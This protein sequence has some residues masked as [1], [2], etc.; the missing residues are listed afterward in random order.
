MQIVPRH[1]FWYSSKVL[2]IFVLCNINSWIIFL[3][4]FFDDERYASQNEYNDEWLFDLKETG[5]TS[6][7]RA[8]SRGFVVLS[9]DSRVD[10]S[11]TGK[12]PGD[13]PFFPEDL[14]VRLNFHG[15]NGFFC[16]RSA[17]SA[18]KGSRQ[19][20]TCIDIIILRHVLDGSLKMFFIHSLHD[21]SE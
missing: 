7:G 4:F 6:G 3:S 1:V 2:H 17:N 12:I 11:A 10:I 13:F 20:E 9:K 21:S 16:R 18:K 14:E 19:S 8:Y 5:R 15:R